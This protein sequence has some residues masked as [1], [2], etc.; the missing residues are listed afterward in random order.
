[1]LI[2]ILFVTSN[3]LNEAYEEV[4]KIAAAKAAGRAGGRKMRQGEVKLRFLN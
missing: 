4:R 3:C 2:W 1:M